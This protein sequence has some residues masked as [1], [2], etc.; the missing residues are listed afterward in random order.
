MARVISRWL[1]D[2]WYGR[3]PLWEA[4][5]IVGIGSWVIFAILLLAYFKT[6]VGR[7]AAVESQFG[8]MYE[9]TWL[10]GSWCLSLFG[11]VSI[12]RCAPNAKWPYWGLGARGYV[13]VNCVVVLLMISPF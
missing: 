9:A 13:V 6:Q 3:R 7:P 8:W 12:W 2:L 10:A 11:L 4:F 1:A 5:W